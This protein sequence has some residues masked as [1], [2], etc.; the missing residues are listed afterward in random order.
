[1]RAIKISP[2]ERTIEEID[3]EDPNKGLDGLRTLVGHEHLRFLGINLHVMVVLADE[4]EPRPGAFRIPASKTPD[5]IYTGDAVLVGTLT[6]QGFFFGPLPGEKQDL[7]RL[8]EWVA[9]G[10]ER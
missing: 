2:A 3:L 10:N 6:K 1:M 4:E 7:E 5:T 8:V 9:P